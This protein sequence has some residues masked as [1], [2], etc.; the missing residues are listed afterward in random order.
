M[1]HPFWYLKLQLNL[2]DGLK[3]AIDV[4]MK[5]LSIEGANR[6]VIQAIK[7]DIRI[8]WGI[9]MLVLDIRKNLTYFTYATISHVFREGNIVADWIAKRGLQLNS[10][11]GLYTSPSPKLSCIIHDD[12]LYR[13][14]KRRATY[15][16][17]VLIHLPKK[18]KNPRGRE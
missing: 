2:C 14:L 11:F 8:P 9:Q 3:A 6:I 16:I 7:G 1:L 15:N 5:H 10:D 13:S 4:G 12:Y 17:F 18:N